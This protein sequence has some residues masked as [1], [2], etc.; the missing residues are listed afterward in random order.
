MMSIEDIHRTSG[1]LSGV[2]LI[3]E[4]AAHLLANRLA[5]PCSVLIIA[6]ASDSRASFQQPSVTHG[7]FQSTT[8]AIYCPYTVG[9]KRE[10]TE[11]ATAAAAGMRQPGASHRAPVEHLYREVV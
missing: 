6:F 11:A 8:L 7:I 3:C 9:K 1:M 5:Q 10:A 2:T 4:T